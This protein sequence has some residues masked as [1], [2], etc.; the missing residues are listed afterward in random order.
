MLGRTSVRSTRRAGRPARSLA[1]ADGTN[2]PSAVG[3]SRSRSRSRTSAASPAIRASQS[4]SLHATWSAR[5]RTTVPARAQPETPRGDRSSA[6]RRNSPATRPGATPTAASGSSPLRPGERSL[7]ATARK[8]KSR[9]GSIDKDYG[10]RRLSL[11][12]V[13]RPDRTSSARSPTSSATRNHLLPARC[14]DRKPFPLGVNSGFPTITE[15][16][17]DHEYFLMTSSPVLTA[18]RPRLRVRSAIRNR[19]ATTYVDPTPAATGIAP[20]G[21]LSGIDPTPATTGFGPTGAMS[22]INPT[23]AVSG[24]DLSGDPVP[25]KRRRRRPCTSRRRKSL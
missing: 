3:T 10:A 8:L 5:S 17:L 16:R 20:S 22:G 15:P 6:R 13:E 19:A 2:S 7:A 24:I 12:A 11:A 25:I 9:R 18:D 4:S 23:L 21:A 14:L 1:T